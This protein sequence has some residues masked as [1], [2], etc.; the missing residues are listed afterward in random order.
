MQ[1]LRQ[2][3]FELPGGLEDLVSTLEA[4]AVHLAAEDHAK[5]KEK[6]LRGILE[7]Y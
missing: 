7:K 4:N 1:Q 2:L 5:A 6:L 3:A